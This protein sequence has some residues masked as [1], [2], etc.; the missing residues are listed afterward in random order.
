MKTAAITNCTVMEILV[1]TYGY[2]KW[3]SNRIQGSQS[4]FEDIMA[5]QI[6]QEWWISS[7]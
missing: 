6:L 2:K 7:E 4:Y 5:T 1:L 3:A